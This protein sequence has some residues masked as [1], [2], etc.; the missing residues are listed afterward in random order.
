VV[1]GF[2]TKNAIG[3]YRHQSCKFESCSWWGILDTTL[4]DKVCQWLV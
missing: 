2:T 1:V 4:C 3:A